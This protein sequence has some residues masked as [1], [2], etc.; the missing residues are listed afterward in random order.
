MIIRT[1]AALE[2]IEKSRVL[3]KARNSF[4]HALSK[5]RAGAGN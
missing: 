3:E 5:V 4:I 2:A 1:A